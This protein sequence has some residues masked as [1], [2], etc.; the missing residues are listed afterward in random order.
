[1]LPSPSVLRSTSPFT[2]TVTALAALLLAATPTATAASAAQPPPFPPPAGIEVNEKGEPQGEGNVPKKPTTTEPGTTKPGTTDPGTTQPGTTQPDTTNPNGYDPTTNP[3]WNPF[4]PEQ[5]GIAALIHGTIDGAFS[6]FRPHTK[7]GTKAGTK[8]AAPKPPPPPAPE[9]PEPIP[10]ANWGTIAD[11]NQ[12]VQADV[13]A[14]RT[15]GRGAGADVRLAEAHL[16]AGPGVPTSA[17]DLAPEPL[18]LESEGWTF[19]TV[20]GLTS[21]TATHGDSVT[22]ESRV[23]GL[24]LGL[25]YLT[26]PDAAGREKLPAPKI[27][28]RLE[29]HDA[30]TTAVATAGQA[31]KFTTSAKGGRLLSNGR[32]L[33][34]FNGP[35]EANKGLRIPADPRRPAQLFVT[36]NEQV[37]TDAQGH[38][39]A[40]EDGGYVRDPEATSGYANTAHITV[41]TPYVMD[42]TVGHAA[43]AHRGTARN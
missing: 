27:P 26:R 35:L 3:D 12:P 21:T 2:A 29:L 1:M 20:Q 23:G 11:T 39:T 42:V 37:T 16:P 7:T 19:G 25:P 17:K 15:L 41:L 13:W 10:A 36:L 43:V 34:A 9:T 33:I 8:A 30:T 6:F 40:G 31:P 18:R 4:D 28:L 14:L 24:T 5:S 32:Q 22:A 38:P